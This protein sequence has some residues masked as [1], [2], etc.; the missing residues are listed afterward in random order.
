MNDVRRL[1]DRSASHRGLLSVQ[2]RMVNGGWLAEVDVHVRADFMAAASSA[3]ELVN[4]L[5]LVCAIKAVQEI[6]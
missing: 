6:L 1:D 2:I 3:E 5:P 4:V